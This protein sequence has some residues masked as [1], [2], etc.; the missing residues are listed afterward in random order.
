MLVV[1]AL[2]KMNEVPLTHQPLIFLANADEWGFAGSR[3][4][5]RDLYAFECEVSIPAD[6][7]SSG[8]PFCLSPLYP[9]TLFQ[10][11]D[12]TEVDVVFS[13]DQIGRLDSADTYFLHHTSVYPN[14]DGFDPHQVQQ[15]EA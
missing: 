3:R 15:Q 1:E 7:S 9:T 4:F 8:M 5:V 2:S 11:I 13:I 6:Q 12:P 14:V 10:S